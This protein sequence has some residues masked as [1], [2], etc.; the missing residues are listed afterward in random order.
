MPDR[1]TDLTCANAGF[2]PKFS[3]RRLFGFSALNT[4]AV[5]GPKVLAGKRSIRVNEA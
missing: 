3:E 4:P 1:R 2:F 5:R